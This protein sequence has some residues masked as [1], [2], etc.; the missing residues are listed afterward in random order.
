M[1]LSCKNTS[2][3][4]VGGIIGMSNN[5]VKNC[6]N[7]ATI[8]VKFIKKFTSES[9]T[10]IGGVA[11]RQCQEMTGCDNTGS[12]TADFLGSTMPLYAGGVLGHNYK[13]TSTMKTCTNSGN[14]TITNGGTFNIGGTTLTLTPLA[15]AAIAGIV[16]NAILPGKDYEFEA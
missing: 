8:S 15:I 4:Y 7:A 3:N 5:G 13:E 9:I 10:Y 14:V 6:D 16:L 11:G 12:I 2:P 1:S